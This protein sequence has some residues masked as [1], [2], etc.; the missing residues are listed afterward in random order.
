MLELLIKHK[1]VAIIRGIQDEHAD[2]A[3]RALIDGGIAL[4][5]ITMNTDGAADMIYRWRKRFGAEAAIGAGTVTD[6]AT[7]RV[8]AEAGAQFL[9]SPNLD[10]DVI[11]FGKEK[12][13][14]VWPGVMT[15]TEIV[16]AVKAGAEAVKL[17]PMGTL[18]IGYLREIRG[19]LNDIPILATGGADLH[20]I[21]D[22]L[23]SGATAVGLGSK[24]VHMEWIRDGRFDLLREQARRFVEA[25]NTDQTN[26]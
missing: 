25:V 18:G 5:E 10:E 16:N 3:A 24:L 12:G 6:M 8:A 13:I 17:F 19:P 9:I 21:G 7:A 2:A 22:Y 4:M 11:A 15:P 23:R 1:I 20:N 14:S 26:Q